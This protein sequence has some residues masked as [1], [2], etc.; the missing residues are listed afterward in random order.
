MW[1]VAFIA[2]HAITG[3]IA[4]ATGLVAIRNGKLFTVYL[5]ALAAMTVFPI[6]AVAAEWST[7]ETPG[8]VLFTTFAVTMAGLALRARRTAR[9]A[10][11][12]RRPATSTSSDSPWSRCSTPSR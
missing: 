10:L 4:L 1:H 8:R 11:P 6:L 3:L 5:V 7:I 2:A 12:D 9:P